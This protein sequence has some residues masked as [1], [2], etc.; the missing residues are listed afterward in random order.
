[1][2]LTLRTLLAYIDDILEPS[3][4]RE[5]G[6]KIAESPV[7]T[8]MVE[9][10]RDVMRRRR[11]TAPELAG[12]GSGPDPN[13]VSEYLDNTLTPEEVSNVERICLESDVHL[14]EVAA[15]H[16]ILTLVLG[17]PVEVSATMRERMYSLGAVA[18]AS[19]GANGH[20][21]ERLPASTEQDMSQPEPRVA[22]S[23]FGSGLPDYG[24][25]RSIWK[26]LVPVVIG[27]VLVCWLG[28]VLTDPT[29]WGGPQLL[30]D[31][32]TQDQSVAQTPV[33]DPTAA[34]TDVP[35]QDEPVVIAG[36]DSEPDS[37]A[38]VA[39]N[40]PPP[41]DMDE[42]PANDDDPA[43]VAAPPQPP[44]DP[45]DDA[46]DPAVDP[47]AKPEDPPP[48]AVAHGELPQ[49][50]YTSQ[51]GVLLRQQT[52]IEDEM[53]MIGWMV[54][55][56]RGFL[57]PGETV[58]SPEPFLSRLRIG[59][60]RCEVLVNGGARITSIG[61]S[62]VS[63][64]G[65]EIEQGRV[66]FLRSSGQDAAAAPVHVDV[67]I[68][69]TLVHLEL[70]EPGTLCGVEVIPIQ[71]QGRPLDEEP[72]DRPVG[73]GLF[74]REGTV[75]VTTDLGQRL[76]M[77]PGRGWLPWPVDAPD[78]QPGNLPVMPNWLSPSG[79]PQIPLQRAMAVRY[80]KNFI[81]DQPA[82]LSV[83]A[84]VKDPNPNMSEYA[85]KTLALTTN[86]RELLRA[87]DA[88]HMESRV[89]AIVGL[90]QWL[91][92]QPGNDEQLR[93]EIEQ[94]F[95]AD[96]AAVVYRLLWGFSIDDFRN[97]E[98]S[99]QLVDWLENGSR[100]VEELALY[101]IRG[102]GHPTEFRVDKRD[103]EKRAAISR[104]RTFLDRNGAFLPPA[105]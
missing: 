7:A 87:L 1:M 85:V 30:S 14:S 102:T 29:F 92:R 84:V 74:V 26:R 51:E 31:S 98:I 19:D 69:E 55:P 72:I 21:R 11:V 39:I 28:L 64:V 76:V 89:A 57:H 27:V 34:P 36:D 60:D 20:G 52:I 75:I 63:L 66:A 96:D 48:P 82:V 53:E 79:A 80:E 83:P 4:A 91:P 100:A 18:G 43:V 17:E 2:R 41:P 6:E 59:D 8:E 37:I 10:V 58:A 45:D 105:T 23:E 71:P 104:L 90:R 40:P 81:A 99:Q 49:V 35:V 5:I 61:P 9:K 97:P 3:D 46:P 94:F 62:D 44:E 15:C 103:V 22:A 93:A 78:A 16:Q 77:G 24:R 32:A 54:V 86:T 12:S 67:R 88:P 33:L 50:M 65:F 56:R 42:A 101:H 13:I 38:P 25:S 47:A 70:A 95:R 73:G 68:G